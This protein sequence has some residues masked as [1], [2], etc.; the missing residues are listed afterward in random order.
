MADLAAV[1]ERIASPGRGILAADEST[2]TIGKRLEKVGL[3]NVEVR[4]LVTQRQDLVVVFIGK[5]L[6]CW[7]KLAVACS[8][9]ATA[10]PQGGRLA[11]PQWSVPG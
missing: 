5:A 11:T 7:Q 2:A 9:S 10:L 8:S 3:Q 6:P 1:A 4:C